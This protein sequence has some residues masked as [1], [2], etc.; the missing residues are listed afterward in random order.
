MVDFVEVPSSEKF[1]ASFVCVTEIK[2]LVNLLDVLDDDDGLSDVLEY[3]TL[4]VA[5]RDG[6]Y[7]PDV[8]YQELMFPQLFEGDSNG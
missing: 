6:S 5:V 2:R 7:T 3:V 1:S 4:C 8:H